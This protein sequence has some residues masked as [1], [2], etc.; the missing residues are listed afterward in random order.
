VGKVLLED[1]LAKVPVGDDEHPLFPPRN[2]KNLLIGEA[3]RI[4]A[5]DHL[6]VVPEIFQVGDEPEVRALVEQELHTAM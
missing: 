2:R 5:G 1:Q 3:G 6:D 4:V